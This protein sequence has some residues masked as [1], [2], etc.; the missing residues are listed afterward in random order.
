LVKHRADGKMNVWMRRYA[1]KP[2]CTLPDPV[3]S[4]TSRLKIKHLSGT[5]IFCA[6]CLGLGLMIFAVERCGTRSGCMRSR[7]LSEVTVDPDAAL[8]NGQ[9]DSQVQALLKDLISEVRALRNA[10]S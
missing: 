6:A 2:R 8:E 3:E 5:F 10:E 4:S 1:V 9:A 7:M